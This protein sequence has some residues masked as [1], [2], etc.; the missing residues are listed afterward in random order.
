MRDE[1]DGVIGYFLIG[2]SKIMFLSLVLHQFSL[3][4][5]GYAHANK[6]VHPW[7]GVSLPLIFP[8]H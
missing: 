1:G 7:A 3:Q 4:V 8:I 6:P 2:N 5:T